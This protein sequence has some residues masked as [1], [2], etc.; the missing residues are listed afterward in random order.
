MTRCNIRRL[1]VIDG[2]RMV[3]IITDW[4]YLQYHLV[5]TDIL[6]SLIEL[7]RDESNFVENQG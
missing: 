2:D 4:I 6:E 7:H 1:A 3:V 5:S